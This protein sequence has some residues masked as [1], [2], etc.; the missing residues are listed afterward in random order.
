[1][2]EIVEWRR[3]FNDDEK[4]YWLIMSLWKHKHVFD[5]IF[6][7]SCLRKFSK[8]AGKRDGKGNNF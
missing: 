6:S 8:D 1:M 2:Q 4:I 3:N 5:W 7:L